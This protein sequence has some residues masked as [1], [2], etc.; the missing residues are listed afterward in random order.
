MQP[1][2]L[3]GGALLSS[4]LLALYVR[5][6]QSVRPPQLLW[7]PTEANKATLLACATLFRDYW[8]HFFAWDGLLST[9]VAAVKSQPLGL[10][11]TRTEVI[12]MEDGGETSLEWLEVPNPKA[13]VLLLPG[14][15]NSSKSIYI[16]QTMKFLAQRGFTTV[17]LNYRGV[18]ELNLKSKRIG[19]ADSYLDLPLVTAHICATCPL[20]LFAIG[21]SMGGGMLARHLGVCHA[22]TK[23]VGAITV[24]A[25]LDFEAVV[26]KLES[27]VVGSIANFWMTW[28]IKFEM[29]RQ[30]EWVAS[31]NLSVTG[32]LSA[33]S[34]R[35][36]EERSICV[37][38]GYSD[39]DDYYQHSSPKSTLN[40][41]RTPLLILTA[42][43]DPVV[44][45]STTPLEII[46]GNPHL[47]LATTKH[48]GHIGWTTTKGITG[49]SWCDH[50]STKFFT[51]LLGT[52]GSDTSEVEARPSRSRL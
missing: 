17:A 42:E 36:I 27:T 24:S 29:L 26:A 15:N 44:D 9:V 30:R 49:H 12:Q 28:P 21:Y 11:P 20:P 7:Q 47:I 52:I 48:G 25:P 22:E 31:N 37:L 50:V 18:G 35:Q 13:V 46:R 32:L 23:I 14:L 19:C 38:H 1:N 5:Y 8:P 40:E 41:V 3:W 43:D 10:A 45:A 39:A 33:T 16:Q 2:A 51:H 4:S 6:V 34:L